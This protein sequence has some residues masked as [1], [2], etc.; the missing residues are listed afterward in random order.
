MNLKTKFNNKKLLTTKKL[1]KIN[2]TN[3][4]KIYLKFLK[5]V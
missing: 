5:I 2:N 4:S 1:L 3:A